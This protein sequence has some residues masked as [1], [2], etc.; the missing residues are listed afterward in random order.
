MS[1]SNYSC[2]V[3]ASN[4]FTASSENENEWIYIDYMGVIIAKGIL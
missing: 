4:M 1:A 3:S 2:V